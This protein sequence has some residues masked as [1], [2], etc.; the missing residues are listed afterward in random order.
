MYSTRYASQSISNSSITGSIS[1]VN[2]DV[3]I[4]IEDLSSEESIILINMIFS[5]CYYTLIYVSI[6]YILVVDSTSLITFNDISYMKV[7]ALFQS[8]EY[9]VALNGLLSGLFNFYLIII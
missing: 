8:T 1:T 3:D 9:I 7:T 2:E 5:N 6:N 4:Y